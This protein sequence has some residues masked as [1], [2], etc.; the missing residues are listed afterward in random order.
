MY[1][2]NNK[3]RLAETISSMVNDPSGSDTLVLLGRYQEAIK[4][5]KK[6]TSQ[7]RKPAKSIAGS[8]KKTTSLKKAYD[9][10]T[11]QEAFEIKRKAK[12]N[13]EDTKEW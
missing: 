13:G 2:G 3:E 9:K 1:I 4:P 6:L 7:A 12:A 10:A 5:T 8:F 11:G